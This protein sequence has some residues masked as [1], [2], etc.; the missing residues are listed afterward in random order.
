MVGVVNAPRTS[1]PVASFTTPGNTCS[2]AMTSR[3]RAIS[4]MTSLESSSAERSALIDCTV[5]TSATTSTV[6]VVAPSCSLISP[7]DR[8]SLEV[9]DIPFFSYC[10]KP[11]TFTIRVYVP[12]CT[13]ANTNSPLGDVVKLRSSFCISF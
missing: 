10:L 7:A 13:L 5:A 11:A 4:C 12:G 8:L 3:P 2:M 9:R 6:S 1:E